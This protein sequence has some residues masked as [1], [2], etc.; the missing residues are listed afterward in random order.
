[1]WTV[2]N[3]IGMKDINLEQKSTLYAVL[4]TWAVKIIIV[5]YMNINVWSLAVYGLPRKTLT[6]L[7]PVTFPIAL[8]A[9]LSLTAA[10]IF[11][12]MTPGHST[13]PLQRA[14]FNKIEPIW[15]FAKSREISEIIWYYFSFRENTVTFV[16]IDPN[17]CKQSASSRETWHISTGF[18]K[19]IQMRFK[20]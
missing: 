16:K 6:Q 2:R 11:Q 4:K 5:T 3:T 13:L 9:L 10:L 15:F 19:T 1:M 18:W 14:P 17:N 7:D 12:T 8:S 20:M